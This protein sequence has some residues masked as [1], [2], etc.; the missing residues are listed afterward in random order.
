MVEIKKLAKSQVE[1]MGELSAPEFDSFWHEAVTNLSQSVKIDGFRPGHIPEGILVKNIGEEAILDAA[2]ELALQ[3]NYHKIVSD[4]KI[5]AIGRPVVTITKIAKNNPLGFK[6]VTA[7]IPEI[8]LPDYSQIAKKVFGENKDKEIL[9]TPK[10][11]GELIEGIKKERGDDFLKTLGEF[12]S[13]ED[14]KMAMESKL[15]LEKELSA[16]E[17][18]RHKVIEAISEESETELPEILI[19]NELDRGISR[20]KAE[21]EKMGLDFN[22]YLKSIKKSLEDIRKESRDKAEKNVRYKLIIRS[23]ARREGLVIPSEE[24]LKEAE[25]LVKIYNVADLEAAKSYVEEILINNKVFHFL[26]GK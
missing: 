23:I 15:K 9:V 25:K 20:M 3:A 11:V 22:E 26:E 1:I 4:N 12:K 2:A 8:K 6:I 16:R 24:I 21:A 19:E 14:L 17:E 5:D 7:V 10:E 13:V 18:V